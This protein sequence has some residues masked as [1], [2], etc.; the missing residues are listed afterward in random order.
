[1]VRLPLTGLFYQPCMIDEEYGDVDGM[2]IGRGNRNTRR[3]PAPAP[4]CPPQIPLDLK[5]KPSRRGGKSWTDYSELWCGLLLSHSAS[6][7]P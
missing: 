1:M 5:S 2:S 6:S 4:I 3:K 7:L